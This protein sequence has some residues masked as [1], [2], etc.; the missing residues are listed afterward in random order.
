MTHGLDVVKYKGLVQET[1]TMR[2]SLKRKRGGKGKNGPE[3]I[4]H[5]M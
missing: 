5:L 2:L 1:K 4:E 3:D